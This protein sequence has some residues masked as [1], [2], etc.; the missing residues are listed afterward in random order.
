MSEQAF[1]DA[2][3][4]SRETS[5]RLRIYAELIEKWNPVIDLV[6][7][8]TLGDLWTRHFVDS[9]QLYRLA[10]GDLRK[11]ADLGSGGGFP[12]LVIA[13][14]AAGEGRPLDMTLVE[15]DQ[16]KAAFLA[17]VARQTGLDLTVRAARIEA[18]EPLGAQVLSAR[19][20][21]PLDQLV[22]HAARHLSPDGVALFPKGAQ[23]AV[24]L[25]RAL[26]KARF[27]Y[28]KVASATDPDAVIYRIWGVS[29]D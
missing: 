7:R 23:H 1:R 26:E 28:E 18:L 8:S 20:L 17:T 5:E 6:S 21:A 25:N 3:D 12:G 11:W 29:R 27:S 14:L 16:R 15:S 4:V 10:A 13:I 24:E 9:A 22:Q 2:Y 19:A